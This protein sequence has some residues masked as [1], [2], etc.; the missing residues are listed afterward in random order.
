MPTSILLEGYCKN[1]H[2]NMHVHTHQCT[3]ENTCTCSLMFILPCMHACTHIC[4]HA[5][6]HMQIHIIYLHSYMNI[7][8][9]ALYDIY[10]SENWMFRLAEQKSNK[11]NLSNI[12]SRR[13][14]ILEKL[15][16][17]KT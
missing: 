11:E 10:N 3:Y 7:K 8:A 2:T 16:N 17:H 4:M 6:M 13:R 9:S 12:F 5:C 15:I 14:V 1:V